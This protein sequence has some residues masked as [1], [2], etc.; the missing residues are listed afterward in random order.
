[1]SNSNDPW[2]V[3]E[4]P[5]FAPVPQGMYL[6]VF[7]G[8]SDFT[9]PTTGEGKWKWTWKVVSGAEKDKIA[10]A[11]TNKG[12]HPTSLPGVLIAGLLGRAI[13]PGENVQASIDGCKGKK[14]MVS[15]AP[16]P[17]GGKPGVRSVGKPPAM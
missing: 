13:T 10:S 2:V 9:L 15:V 17:K 12:I 1:M 6:A 4:Q 16:G 5:T 3:G 11:L 7:D 8:V 14:Y